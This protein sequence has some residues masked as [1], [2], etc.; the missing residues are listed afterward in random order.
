MPISHI[1][2][3]NHDQVSVVGGAKM[4]E[5]G[6]CPVYSSTHKWLTNKSNCVFVPSCVFVPAGLHEILLCRPL[7]CFAHPL[8]CVSILVDAFISQSPYWLEAACIVLN[9]SFFLMKVLLI[10]GFKTST[11]HAEHVAEML[12]AVWQH[13][14]EPTA[15]LWLGMQDGTMAQEVAGA[16]DEG[17]MANIPD[18]F[19]MNAISARAAGKWLVQVYKVC[20]HQLLGCVA[21]F[22]VLCHALLTHYCV[23][24]TVLV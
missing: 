6:N 23:T 12:A 11:A 24:G 4:M 15:E 19:S 21:E 8:Q 20:S 13:T 14:E 17:S 9:V 16:A 10:F 5:G 1:S 7:G 18:G 2:F 3:R 22:D